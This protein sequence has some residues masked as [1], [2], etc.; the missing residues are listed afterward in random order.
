MTQRKNPEDLKKRGRKSDFKQEYVKLAYNYSLL[1]ATD[2]Q[3]SEYFGVTEK[4]LNTWKK[5]Y[6][7]F[8]QSLKAG[9]KEADSKVA[10]K[11][12]SRAI[13]Y[14]YDE[15]HIEKKGRKVIKRR[16]IK[17]HQPAD[18]TAQIFWLKNRQPEIWRD[19]VI[20]ELHGKDGESLNPTVVILPSNSRNDEKPT[21]E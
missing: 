9:K 20:N 13:G 5:N 14:N 15:I 16:T 4:T 8:L 7:D 11:L 1:G 19:K 18:T 21:D 12:F 2:V 10:E 17:K 6:P 3:M